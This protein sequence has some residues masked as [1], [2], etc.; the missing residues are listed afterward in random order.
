MK[1]A[2][3]VT[4]VSLCVAVILSAA[5][6][7]AAQAATTI[8]NLNASATNPN[9]G[10]AS[11]SA[12]YN[13][14]NLTLEAGQ[15]TIR[16]AGVAGGGM[17]DAYSVYAPTAA[18]AAWTDSRWSVS[19][20]DGVSAVYT[21]ADIGGTTADFDGRVKAGRYNS[22]AAALSA[23]SSAVAYTLN[24]ASTQTVSFY[25]DDSSFGDNSGGVSIAVASVPEPATLAI[26]GLGA[27]AAAFAVRRRRV[28]ATTA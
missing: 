1:P 10:K 22:A 15:Y 17:Y 3:L 28:P 12:A 24:L 11:G 4:I 2:G 7:P 26:L 19:L 5:A 8:V 23:Y 9:A 21:Q 20:N 14:V 16:V 25:V 18:N 6:S 13:P 27:V